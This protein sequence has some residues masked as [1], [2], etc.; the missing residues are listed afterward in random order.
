ADVA[1]DQRR[2]RAG[3]GRGR[4][5][6]GAVVAPHRRRVARRL[7]QLSDARRAEPATLPPGSRWSRQCSRHAAHVRLDRGAD[8]AALSADRRQPRPS[9][10]RRAAA[11]R[12]VAGRKT[13]VSGAAIVT[14]AS[15]A[16]APDETRGAVLVSG[17][18]GGVYNAWHAL[19]RGAR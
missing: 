5:L 19:R 2:A 12:R 4:A 8:G 18:Y 11:Q 15:S 17:S 9:F 14:A 16:T 3:R 7:V 6:P 13:G 1:A 10:P